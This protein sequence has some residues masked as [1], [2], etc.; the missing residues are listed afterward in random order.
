LLVGYGRLLCLLLGRFPLG[1]PPPKQPTG[2][3]N[4]SP[5]GRSLPRIASNGTANRPNCR[6]SRA[7]PNRLAA[8]GALAARL[9]CANGSIGIKACLLHGP[10]VTF[11][12]ILCLLFLG[13][14]LLGIDK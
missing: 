6:A 3:P 11:I 12:L 14:T 4:S 1:L 7:A 9:R 5:D 13:L 8:Y 10:S 2:C